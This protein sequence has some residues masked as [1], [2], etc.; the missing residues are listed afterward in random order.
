VKEAFTLGTQGPPKE[1][2]FFEKRA[3]NSAARQRA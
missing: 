1:A 3:P 2:G